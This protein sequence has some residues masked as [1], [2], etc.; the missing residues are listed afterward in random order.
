MS[1]AL[2][3]FLKLNGA[4]KIVESDNSS[5][6]QTYETASQ[7]LIPGTVLCKVLWKKIVSR[8]WLLG[9][10]PFRSPGSSILEDV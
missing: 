2:T 5:L 9:K 4:L 6:L 10:N 3:F 7:E 8:L 1:D